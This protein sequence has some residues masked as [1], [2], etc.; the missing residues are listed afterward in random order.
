MTQAEDPCPNCIK[1]EKNPP[2][3]RAFGNYICSSCNYERVKRSTQ[4]RFV[5]DVIAAG[6]W[7]ELAK[8][9]NNMAYKIPYD[10]LLPFYQALHAEAEEVLRSM[11]AMN[12]SADDQVAWKEHAAEL[13]EQA[14]SIV[15]RRSLTQRER[16]AIAAKIQDKYYKPTEPGA[17][18]EPAPP[19]TAVI[20]GTPEGICW[21]TPKCKPKQGCFYAPS[22]EIGEPNAR[23]TSGWGPA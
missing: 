17:R 23:P 12:L 13:Y 7:D 11:E 16:A 5:K 1:K 19:S 22:K 6:S 9:N 2:N 3:P 18:S 14:E 20:E 15:Q 21:H 4:R 8:K 10:V